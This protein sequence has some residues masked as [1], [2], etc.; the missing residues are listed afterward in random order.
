MEQNG[1]VKRKRVGVTPSDTTCARSRR[2]SK[3]PFVIGERG[4]LVLILPRHLPSSFRLI[5]TL[6]R[7]FTSLLVDPT[8]RNRENGMEWNKIE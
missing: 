5:R 1:C 4:W 8:S 7:P 6:C 2:I 3:G